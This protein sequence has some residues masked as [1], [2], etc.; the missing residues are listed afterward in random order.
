M[1][2]LAL[3][4]KRI[5]GRKCSALAPRHIRNVSVCKADGDYG[6]CQPVIMGDASIVPP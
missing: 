4:S 6:G 5:H 1:S 3:S 2:F